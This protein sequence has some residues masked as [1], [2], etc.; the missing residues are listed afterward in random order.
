[1]Q[2]SVKVEHGRSN[3]RFP[4]RQTALIVFGVVAITVGLG[5]R[6]SRWAR[7]RM[8]KNLSVEQLSLAIRDQP[9][10]ALTFMYYGSAL[11]AAGNNQEAEQAFKRAAKLEPKNEKA[12][13]GTASS[14]YRLNKLD[15][16][17]VSFKAAIAG[18]SMN[19]SDTSVSEVMP[20]ASSAARARAAH[21]S[22]ATGWS[23]CSSAA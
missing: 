8:L 14:Q 20:S 1:M 21:R 5:I 13:L 6:K 15:D 19:R 16:A 17:V 18:S 4:M 11:L 9:D 3:T 12:V 10:D 23:D 7:E 22:T 2:Q